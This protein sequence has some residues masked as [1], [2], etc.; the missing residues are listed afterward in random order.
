MRLVSK[1]LASRR[2]LVWCQTRV[3][4]WRSGLG[5]A[6]DTNNSTAVDVGHPMRED[7]RVV[8]LG[9]KWVVKCK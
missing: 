1:P 3:H 6:V 9:M 2:V 5:K 7:M 8:H 4:V